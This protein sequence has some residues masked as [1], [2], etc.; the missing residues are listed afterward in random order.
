MQTTETIQKVAWAVDPIHS[1]VNFKVKHMMMTTV[2]GSFDKFSIEAETDGDDF[3][4]GDV[5]FTAETASVNTGNESRDNHLRGE[6]FFYAEKF[7]ELT[8]RPTKIEAVDND[9]SY[10]IEGDLTIRDVTKAISLS[11]E[12]GGLVKDP[13]GNTRAGFTINGKINRKDWNL[14]WNV[15]LEAGGIL[16]SDE[17]RI[18]CE[19]QLIRK[20]AIHI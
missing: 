7:P 2:T 12:F 6:D 11:A 10:T 16:V 4:T 1:M 3:T 14:N 19:I 17:V 8:F 5:V 9:G 15:A 18:N 13:W 20:D